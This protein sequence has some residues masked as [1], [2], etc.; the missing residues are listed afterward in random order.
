MFFRQE[1][2]AHAVLAGRRQ[3]NALFQHLGAIEVVGDLDQD[4]GS[5]AHQRV[6]THR[7]A[8]VQVLEDLQ[9]LL[10]DRVRLLA[11][12]VRDEAD[13]ARV[14]LLRTDVEAR[15]FGLRDLGSRGLRTGR[16]LG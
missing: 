4:A 12:D 11:G 15:G 8:M 6:G 13:T 14:V 5:V 1:Y 7:A 10:D 3:A 2:H 9:A 16:W